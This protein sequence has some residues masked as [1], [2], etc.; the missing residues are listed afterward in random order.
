MVDDDE[1]DAGSGPEWVEIRPGIMGMTFGDRDGNT[2]HLLKETWDRKAMQHANL[3]ANWNAFLE[4]IENHDALWESRK[5]PESHRVY[6]KGFLK[7]R[8]QDGTERPGD[9]AIV[10]DFVRETVVSAYIAEV[11]ALFG[12]FR[13]RIS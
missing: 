3:A 7:L 10:V 1:D 12:K 11:G 2:V 8:H 9:L 6:M 4:T 5:R 13:R